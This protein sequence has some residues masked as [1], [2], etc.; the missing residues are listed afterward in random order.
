M[1]E[2]SNR[3]I[4]CESHEDNCKQKDR[5]EALHLP[6]TYPHQVA[7]PSPEFPARKMMKIHPL[8]STPDFFL[9]KKINKLIKKVWEL[10]KKKK[11]EWS[12]VIIEWIE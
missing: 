11:T 6:P 12:E 8:S 7:T 3:A 4:Q 9:E 5:T 2:T 1:K 10:A